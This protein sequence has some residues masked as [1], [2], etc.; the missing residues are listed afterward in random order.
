MP[1]VLSR[2]PTPAPFPP[3]FVWGVAT[4]AP[5]VEGA[6]DADGKSASVWDGF[7]RR[8]G[9][10]ARGDTPAVACDHYHR[11]RADF[12]LMAQLGV[13]HHRLSLAWPR[14]MPDGDGRVNRA[15]VDHYHRVIDA[16]LER[17]ITPWVTMFHWD[18]PQALEARGGWPERLVA[19]AFADYADLIVRSYGDRVK[20]W[21][22]LNEI[23]VFVDN[24]YAIGRHAPGRK[25]K[26]E[27][28]NQAVHHALV[29]HGHGVRAVREHGGAGAVVGLCDNSSVP[30]PLVE[31]AADIAAAEALFAAQSCRVLEPIYRGT[32]GR[33]YL[34]FTSGWLPQM[35]PTD[36]E[37]ITQP[38]DFLGL[39]LYS[40]QCVRR[41]PDG[42][43][44]ALAYPVH[45]PVADS[46]W[47]KLNARALY[48]GPRLAA[49]VFGVEHLYI[50]ENGAGYD[51][52]PPVNGELFDLHRLEYLRACLREL[53]RASDD[54][55]P[56]D[57]Y[58]VWSFLDNFEWADGNGR[59][60]GIVHNDFATQVRTPKASAAW[61]SRVCR[62][63]ALV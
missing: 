10:V 9:A 6:A 58:F 28:V 38:T 21:I 19:D 46:P 22:T 59:R 20:H 50:L 11:Y 14:L 54:G 55:V 45:Y 52:T 1:A 41:G 47:L 8:P 2:A 29:G 49:R 62:Q 16:L 39:N 36:L 5:Q 27:L 35:A 56:V 48:W 31:E 13:R 26:A 18:L 42:R 24:G 34:D 61:F 25:E 32:Y 51:E 37:L 60:F 7:A 40:G 3:G 12:D 23:R 4:A 53:K 57:G 43:P 15:G 63:N 33:T 17:G 44:E 30:I